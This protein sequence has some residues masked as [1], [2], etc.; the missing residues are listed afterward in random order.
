MDLIKVL[1]KVYT[2]HWVVDYM[3]TPLF[4]NSLKNISICDPACGQGD[5]LVPIAEEILVRCKNNKNE[6]HAYLE[7]LRKLSGYDIDKGAVQICKERLSSVVR[8]ILAENFPVDFWNI[9]E[10]DALD[11]W[12]DNRE[13]FDWVIGNPP[14][15]RIQNLESERR[16]KIKKAGWKYFHGNSDLYIVF[17]ELGMRLLKKGGHLK[18]ISPSGWMRNGAGK[19]MRKDIESNSLISLCSL[20]DFRD[21]QVF[22]NVSTYTCITHLKKKALSA[23]NNV[24]DSIQNKEDVYPKTLQWDRKL[25]SFSKP[26]KLIKTELRWGIVGCTATADETFFPKTNVRKSRYFTG[27]SS[28]KLSDIADIKVGIQTLADKIFILEVLEYN[29]QDVLVQSLQKIKYTFKIE[30][31]AIKPILKASVLKNGKDQID[32]VI[33]YPYN[34]K[35]KLIPELEFSKKFPHAYQWLLANKTALCSRD[36]GTFCTTKWYGYGRDVGITSA[37]G[38]KILTSGIN[39]KPNFQICNNPNTLFYSG[40][41]IKP[42]IDVF[43]LPIGLCF[44]DKFKEERPAMLR[45]LMQILNSP[46]MDNHIKTFSQPFQNGWYSYAKRYIEDFPIQTNGAYEYNA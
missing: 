29:G 34:Q 45:Y 46:E 7:T 3:L 6:R 23:T 30:E 44:W 24:Q 26:S 37:F 12:I 15:V 1:G 41:S 43:G 42:K 39:P 38:Q 22:P 17:F 16:N 13:Q 40:Y 8:N 11:A 19:K 18:F 21:F 36:K 4:E 32:R 35:G 27:D 5:F 25:K 14:Y 10:I 9:K 20:C 28:I 31:K 33:I 2:P